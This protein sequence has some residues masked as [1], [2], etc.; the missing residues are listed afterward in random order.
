MPGLEILLAHA[1]FSRYDPKQTRKMKPYPPLATLH[2]AGFLRRSGH[3]VT[4]FDAML[5]EGEHAF[6][7]ALERASPGLVVLFEDNFNFLSKMCLSRMRQAAQAMCEMAAAAGCIVV[8]S[9]SDM[10]D[11]PDLY[12]S[13]G[14]DAVALGEGDHAVRDIAALLE[15]LPAFE[16]ERRTAEARLALQSRAPDIAGLAFL[17]SSGL[18]RS[19]PRPP[20]RQPDI[21]GLPAWDLV[22]FAKYEEV[23]R[24]PH[25][26]FSLNMASTRGCPFHCNWCAK[27]IWGQR[28]AMRSPVSVADEMALLKATAK[29]D[30]I[31]FADDI[32]G[33]RPGWVAEFAREIGM[34]DGRI[35]FTIQSRVDLMTDDAVSG[36][37]QAGC[38]EVWL[39][40]ESGSQRV[41]DTMDKGTRVDDIFVARTRLRHAGI[42]ACFFVQFGYAGETWED[43]EAT[44][45]MIAAADPD[46][47]GVSVSYPLPGTRFHDM[48]RAE[49][50]AKLNWTDSDD[51]EM[52][53]Q[54]A[55]PTSFY[56]AL[57]D[58]AHLDLDAR[59]AK[60]DRTPMAAALSQ[61]RERAWKRLCAMEPE[62]RHASPTRLIKP[63][64]ILA[65]PDLSRG[66]N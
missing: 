11:R 53:F 12:L 36:L 57:R 65:T 60:R 38:E 46:E 47:I 66:W 62:A 16:P 8:V 13:R 5:S 63:D 32:F 3:R 15:H 50:G 18:Q 26:R 19:S 33:L 58:Y 40:A 22:D 21:F 45:D 39:G 31:W 41:L 55:Y 34:R 4:L 52:L 24:T 29:P 64:E 9:G 48:V 54:G 20:E 7:A 30:H 43:I 44:L 37:K 61:Q 2:V 14:A 17:G 23:W 49:L 59:H 27:P 6:Q 42:R 10:T 56:R 28:Y 1:Y 25:G 35:P 51:L